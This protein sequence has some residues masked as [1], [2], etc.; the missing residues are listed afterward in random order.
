[1]EHGPGPVYGLP[2]RHESFWM[3]S[4]PETSHPPLPGNLETDVAVVGGGITGITTAFL[5]KRAGYTVA[6]IEGGRVYQ[7]VTGHT[8]AKVTS[9]HRLI[10][11]ELISRFG[12][13]QAKQYADANQAAI[14]A[15]ASIVREYEIP[16]DFVRR[17]AYTYAESEDDRD[18]V[19]AEADAA[20]SLGLPATFVEETGLQCPHG[21]P[22]VPDVLWR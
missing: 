1:M 14:E 18:L 10:Y 17:P 19:M 12:G 4:T 20:R 16:C 22:L 21:H 7:G 2:G 5:L 6:V 3:E 8:T 11:R 9:L 15:I 13:G